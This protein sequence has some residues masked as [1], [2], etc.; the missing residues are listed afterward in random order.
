MVLAWKFPWTYGNTSQVEILKIK[1]IRVE[2]PREGVISTINTDKG[3]IKHMQKKEKKEHK[4]PARSL[5]T[6]PGINGL[7]H[8]LQSHKAGPT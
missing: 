1:N 7:K 8:Q 4:Q 3:K 5:I 2:I 6:T